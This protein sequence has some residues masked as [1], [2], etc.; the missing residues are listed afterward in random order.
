[1]SIIRCVA[2]TRGH[3]RTAGGKRAGGTTTPA[4]WCMSTAE[5]KTASPDACVSAV[6]TP[7]R[8]PGQRGK[9][10]RSADIVISWG[11][12]EQREGELNWSVVETAIANARASGGVITALFWTGIWGPGWMYNANATT[13]REA[14]PVL[15][16]TDGS[17]A[18]ASPQSCCPDYTSPTYQRMLRDR[19]AA[20]ADKLR[21]LK[22]LGNVVVGFQPC[23]GSTGDDTPIHL[24]DGWTVLNETALARICGN[25]PGGGCADLDPD[26]WWHNFTRSF[27]AT[28]A[29]DPALFGREVAEDLLF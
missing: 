29:T 17:T 24:G 10:L 8:P 23:V 28:L 19:H 11:D 7:P 1:M 25:A 6:T 13:G 27:A 5:V 26:S 18:C 14:V 9:L 2:A 20:L 15:A 4:C 21:A 16:S 12:I 3:A 22:A